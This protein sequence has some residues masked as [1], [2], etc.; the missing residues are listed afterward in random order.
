VFTRTAIL[1]WLAAVAV[2][3]QEPAFDAASV[4]VVRLAP[5]PVFGNT[6]GPGTS[7]PDRVHLCCVGM[8]PLVMRAYDVELDQISGPSWIMDNM[9]PNLM[10]PNLYQIDATMPANTTRAEFQ[11]MMRNLLAERFHLEAHRE[12]RN[13]PGYELVVADGGPKLNESRPDPNFVDSDSTQMPKRNADGALALPPRPQMFTSLGRG[14]VIVQAQEKPI[15]DLVKVLGRQI[16]Q[17]LGEDPNDFASPKPRVIDKTCLTGKFD[18]TLRF[19]CEGCQFSAA[20]GML[21][22]PPNRTDAPDGVPNIFVALQK[23]LG[24]KLVKVKEIPLDVI[25]IDHVD[26]TPTAN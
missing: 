2:L 18:F 14:M 10:G 6:G 16:A 21:S 20:N 15:N 12:R 8:F 19:S 25:V 17:S 9:G 23:Q 5:H 26:K 24:L 4:K 1:S 7:D 22:G 11:L 3:G 13:F